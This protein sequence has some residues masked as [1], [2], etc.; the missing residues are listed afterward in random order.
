MSI[1]LELIERVDNGEKFHIDFEKRT[2]KVGKTYL[3]KD[4]EYDTSRELFPKLHEFYD[5]NVVLHCI[6]D[7]Y[8]SYKYSMPSERSESKRRKY[9]KALPLEEISDEQ[10]MVAQKRETAQARLEGLVL[11]AIISGD[12]VW[13]DKVMQGKWFYQY[14]NDPDLI[15]L[16]SW[17]EN[18]NK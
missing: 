1:Y 16:K 11:C 4:G 3:I 8:K 14:K 12:L 17:V 13:D 7:L 15:I 18:K 6:H 5:L 10:L 2:M 9:F